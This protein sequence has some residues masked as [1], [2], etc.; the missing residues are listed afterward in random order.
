[1][2]K[3]SSPPKLLLRFFRWY[4][5]PDYQEDIE[6]DLMERF[7]G[8]VEDKGIKAAKWGFAKDVIQL[9]RPGIIRSLEGNYQLNNYGMFKTNIKIASRH[10]LKNKTYSLIN[11]TLSI[12]I[13]AYAPKNQGK[14]LLSIFR[15]IP[16]YCH[17]I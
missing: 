14:I 17:T 8:M 6:G 7:E 13:T 16:K 15:F 12:A 5:H 1:M 10:L 2:N 11:C 3:K 4:C 9:F